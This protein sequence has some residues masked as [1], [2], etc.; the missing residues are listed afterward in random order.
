MYKVPATSRSLGILTFSFSLSSI[1]DSV[2][3]L[4]FV[5][6][7]GLRLYYYY[8]FENQYDLSPVAFEQRDYYLCSYGFSKIISLVKTSQQFKCHLSFV[9]ST[10]SLAVP[11]GCIQHDVL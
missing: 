2:S 8:Y 9:P 11:M 7:L 1:H 3:S 4:V 5:V 6:F 10:E